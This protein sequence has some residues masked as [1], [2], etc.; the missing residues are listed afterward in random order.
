MPDGYEFA[1][2]VL[3]SGNAT[4]SGGQ[5]TMP[6][7]GVSFKAVLIRQYL[8][9]YDKGS[10][11]AASHMPGNQVYSFGVVRMNDAML[12]TQCPTAEGFEFVGWTIANGSDSATY[13]VSDLQS[14]DFSRRKIRSTLFDDVTHEATAVAQWQPL[15]R[16][17]VSYAAQDENGASLPLTDAIYQDR[18]YLKGESVTVAALLPDK[19]GYTFEGWRKE[20]QTLAA[21]ATFAMPEVDVTLTGAYVANRHH[22]YYYDA[23]GSTPLADK[24]YDYGVSVTVGEGVASPSREGFTFNGW[25]L[26]SGS[27]TVTA[28]GFTMP[29]GNVA[30]EADYTEHTYTLRYMDGGTLLGTQT[31]SY[32]SLKATGGMVI[33]QDDPAK[34]RFTFKCWCLTDA[35]TTPAFR[36]GET[37]DFSRFG[38]ERTATLYAQWTPLPTFTVSYTAYDSDHHAITLDE[39]TYAAKSYYAGDTVTVAPKLSKTSDST[40]I[41]WVYN[42]MLAY[43]GGQTFTMPSE[44]MVLVGRYIR[45]SELQMCDI[46]YMSGVS[47]GADGWNQGLGDNH[48]FPARQGTEHIIKKNDDADIGYLRENYEF[49]GWNITFFTSSGGA[50]PQEFSAARLSGAGNGDSIWDMQIKS[51]MVYRNVTLTAVWDATLTY[52]ANGGTGTVPSPQTCRSGDSVTVADGSGLIRD[53]YTFAGWNP[54]STA[55]V[56]KHAPGSSIVLYENTTLYAVWI[57]NG[58]NVTLTY[59]ANGGSGTVP[60]AKSYPVGTSVTVASGNGLSRKNAA[61]VCWNTDPQRSGKDYHPGDSIVMTGNQTLYAIWKPVSTGNSPYYSL[62]YDANGATSGTAPTDAT[63]YAGGE[64]VTVAARGN[65]FR[66]G[67]T[68]V[69]WNTR[70]D[71]TGTGYRDGVDV[72]TMPKADVILY[73]VWKDPDGNTVYDSPHTGEDWLPTWF[74]LGAAVFS[75]FVLI[76][77]VVFVR[78]RER[79]N[80]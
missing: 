2:W 45:D 69:E 33:S 65:L 13:S 7:E 16:Y 70:R 19:T 66:T 56:S 47:R 17:T 46:T 30:F 41:G 26:R 27:V 28:G 38:T 67:C 75:A 55:S 25:K 10:V 31:A 57:K 29:D 43:N 72:L 21:G 53:G 20:T 1:E 9:R 79:L 23:G 4:V 14:S 12:D 37:V 71:G 59:D 61:F 24:T 74:A 58:T 32:T 15:A 44:D 3:L 78:R 34:E 68:F 39:T 6:A 54:E 64:K 35:D 73:A 52:D 40:F 76:S 50:S 48:T 8:L 22:V 36:K 60:A 80:P 62:T 77:A 42:D 5:F 49:L 11:A 18:T 51:F 63:H